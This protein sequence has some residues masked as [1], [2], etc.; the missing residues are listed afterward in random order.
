MA[1]QVINIGSA[2]NDHTGDPIRTGGDKINDNFAE[3]YLR[4]G[5]DG[6]A[7]ADED[8]DP[9]DPVNLFDDS[10][11]LK[12]Q[13]ADAADTTKEADAFIREAV[14]M[15]DTGA[16]YGPGVPNDAL[17]GLTAGVV[18]YLAVGGGVTDTLPT[19]TLQG[20]QRLG[21]ATSATTIS[22]APEPMIEA[23]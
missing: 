17:A 5:I 4:A 2:G 22:F 9:G 21:K 19:T 1:R 18:Y 8:L 16:F 23:P 11:T 15:G 20:Q 10:G 7:E 3:L 14:A 13:K 6:V 12:M